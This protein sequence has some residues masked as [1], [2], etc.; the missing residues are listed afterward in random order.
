M[1][2]SKP[3][4]SQSALD[5]A[6]TVHFTQSGSRGPCNGPATNFLS[7]RASPATLPCTSSAWTVQASQPFL[8]TLAITLSLYTRCSLHWTLF[9]Q[10]MYGHP[11]HASQAFVLNGYSSPT[12]WDLCLYSGTADLQNFFLWPSNTLWSCS[13]VFSVCYLSPPL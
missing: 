7:G 1:N 10:M 4:G 6:V 5:S 13:F 9:P 12:F 3:I 8:N 2:V 11:H